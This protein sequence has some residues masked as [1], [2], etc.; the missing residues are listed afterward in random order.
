MARPHIPALGAALAHRDF[1]LFWAGAA[2]SVAGRQAGMLVQAWLVFDI[3]GS[4]LQ[5]GLIGFVRAVPSFVLGLAGGVVA[6]RIDRRHLSMATTV[7]GAVI[8]AG[9]GAL[10]LSGQLAVWHVLGAGFL[11]GAVGAFE[12]PARQSMFPHLVERRLLTNAVALVAS[13]NPAVRIVVPVIAG[14]LIDRAGTGVTGAAVALY[15]VAGLYATATFMLFLVRMPRVE[16]S[17]SGGLQSLRE[18]LGFLRVHGLLR[19]LLVMS[20]VHAFFGMAYLAMLPVFAAEFSEGETGSTLG[21][22]HAVGGMGG[23]AGAMAMGGAKEGGRRGLVLI[24]AGVGFGASLILFS[25]TPWFLPGLVLL[26]FVSMANNVYEVVAQSTLHRQVP[27]DYRGRIMGF[28]GMQFNVVNPLGSLGMG[29]AA[30]GIGAPLAVALGGAIVIA[31]DLL[32]ASPNR[33]L[34]ELRD[35]APSADH[36]SPN[37]PRTSS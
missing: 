20:F 1:R 13:I 27:D 19:F 14:V 10:V 12:G 36:P 30:T 16:R 31:F 11:A 32:V 4:A 35:D 34:R 29:L 33:R 24:G 23:L 2:L 37:A 7:G 8:W 15:M 17:V 26:F 21:V 5:L 22:L 25:A 3:T 9:L 6:D 18:G 28:W